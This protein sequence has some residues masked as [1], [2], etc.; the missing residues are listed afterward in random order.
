MS[1]SWW[2]GERGEWYVALQ[3][4]LFVVLFAAPFLTPQRTGWPSPWNMVGMGLGLLLGVAGAA[5]IMAGLLSLGQNLTAVPHP[6]DD[7][8]LVEVGAYKIVRHPIYSGII[9]GAFGWGFLMNNLPTLALAVVLFI[10]FDIKSR[11]E[12]N[13]LCCKFENYSLYQQRV[14]KLIP[15]LY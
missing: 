10:F 4:V 5:L 12:E 1:G 11:R 15:Y 3:F 6:K 14:R 7:A 2:K 8:T 9:L 13:A